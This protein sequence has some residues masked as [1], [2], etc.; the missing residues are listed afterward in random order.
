MARITLGLGT[1]HGPMLSVPSQYWKDRVPADRAN[2][3][4]FYRG[5]TYTFE[6][7]AAL[8][9]GENLAS[10]ITPDELETRHARCQSAIRRLG[11]LYCEAKPDVAV[12]VG[13]DQMEVFTTEQIPVFAVFWGPYVEGIP[14][15][16]EFLDKLPPGVARAELDRTPSQY[17]QYPCA[18][19][20]GQ[21]LI[22]AAMDAGFDVAQM[23]KLPA[24]QIGSNAAPHA[25]GFVYRRVF[26][27]HVVPHVPVFVN[28]FYPPNQPRA[29][30]CF[31]F[32]RV[33]GRAIANWPRHASVLVVASGGMSHFVVDE[34][35]DREVIEF[36]RAG[37]EAALS[38]IP[39]NMFQAGTSEIKNWI[40]VAGVMA[41]AGLK[42]TLVDYVPCYRSEAGSGS[43]LGFAYW[44]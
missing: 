11:D 38:R 6:E 27:D 4:H 29:A 1:S 39:E 9:Q 18:P 14:R 35:F 5:N 34:A 42:M 19:E 7:M 8:R 16:Q 26:R 23:Q 17:T 13:N 36:I 37:D 15:T 28:T 44:Q 20:L 2:P 41:E 21:H 30:R 33:L 12:V 22:G 40:T 31:E 10:Q 32:G 3:R 43:G 25:Y 24:G